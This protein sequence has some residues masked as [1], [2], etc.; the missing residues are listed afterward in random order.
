M[1]KIFHA[2]TANMDVGLPLKAG[3]LQFQPLGQGNVVR[4]HPG[5]VAPTRTPKG[6]VADRGPPP[7]DWQAFYAHPAVSPCDRRGKGKGVVR[8]T[9]VHQ[10]QLKVFKRL[11]ENGIHGLLQMYGGIVGGHGHGYFGPVCIHGLAALMVCC[12]HTT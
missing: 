3:V 1:P 7:V 4:V 11:R 12:L 2:R 9:I 10:Q 6:H 8:R 5:K